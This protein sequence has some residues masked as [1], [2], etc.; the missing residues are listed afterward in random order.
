MVVVVEM[1]PDFLNARLPPGHVSLSPGET[2]F[3]QGSIG[4]LIYVIARGEVDIVCEHADG[5]EEIRVTL[6]EGEYFGEMGPLFGLPRSA[7]AKARTECELTGYTVQD[8]RSRIGDAGMP[9]VL[10]HAATV[11]DDGD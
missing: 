8:F 5:T 3:R 11:R 1:V 7:S 9:A 4:L 6:G 2:L 10:D